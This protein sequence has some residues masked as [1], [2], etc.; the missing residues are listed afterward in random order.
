MSTSDY[1]LALGR[2]TI[3]YDSSGNPV[4]LNENEIK[5][6]AVN[7]ADK[8]YGASPFEVYYGITKKK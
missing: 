3:Y 5:T 4:G 7:S 1:S 2:A 8:I 6:R